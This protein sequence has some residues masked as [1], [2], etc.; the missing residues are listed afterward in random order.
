M[1]FHAVK[2][3]QRYIQVAQVGGSQVNKKTHRDTVHATRE[4]NQGKGY[5]GRG[6][7]LLQCSNHC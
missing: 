1:N 7:T 3:G 2:T 4:N 5:K 6:G